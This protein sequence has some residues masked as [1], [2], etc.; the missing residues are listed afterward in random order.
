MN[1]H[2]HGPW[3]IRK[4]DEWT[5][6]IVTDDL[7]MPDGTPS[8]WNIATANGNRTEVKANVRLIAAA[9]DLLEALLGMV[10]V[11][12]HGDFRNGVTC[13]TGS[14]DEGNV[15]A[16]GYIRNAI[17]AIQKATGEPQ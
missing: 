1:N 11:C 17:K 14:I 15:I 12:E 10:A 3:L 5:N 9:P 2:T 8:Y 6:D 13:Q 16:G 4:G 7:P